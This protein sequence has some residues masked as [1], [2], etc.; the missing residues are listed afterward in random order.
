MG[1]HF[2]KS[3]K[4]GTSEDRQKIACEQARGTHKLKSIGMSQA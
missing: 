1:T 2:L 4:G 3:P